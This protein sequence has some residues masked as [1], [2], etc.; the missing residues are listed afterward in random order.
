MN[1][2]EIIELLRNRHSEDVFIKECYSSPSGVWKMD[3][4]VIQGYWSRRKY[5]TGDRNEH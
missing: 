2:N 4:W 5:I 3:A 1:A